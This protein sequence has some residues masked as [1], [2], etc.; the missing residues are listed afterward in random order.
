MLES[1]V[2]FM[3]IT[4]RDIKTEAKG[5]LV[6]QKKQGAIVTFISFLL[7]GILSPSGLA[8]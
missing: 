1:G 8:P 5:R 7:P 3:N 6:G 4:R 2:H